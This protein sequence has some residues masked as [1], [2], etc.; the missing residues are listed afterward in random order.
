MDYRSLNKA[1]IPDKFLIPVIEE[2]LDELHGTCV[3]SKLDLKSGYHQ[4][5]VWEDDIHKTSFRPHE[6]HYYYLFILDKR[7]FH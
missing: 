4:I 2:L 6:G 5:R 3:F 7:R 1:T